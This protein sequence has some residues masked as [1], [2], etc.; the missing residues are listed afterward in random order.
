MCAAIARSK[1]AQQRSKQF[2][3]RQTVIDAI[4]D[5][6]VSGVAS[7]EPGASP[8]LNCRSWRRKRRRVYGLP[9]RLEAQYGPKSC[10]SDGLAVGD[11]Q[12][13]LRRLFL[14]RT[15][16][17]RQP[18][19]REQQQESV[20]FALSSPSVGAT[21]TKA[22]TSPKRKRENRGISMI[23]IGPPPSGGILPHFGFSPLRVFA[24]NFFGLT[25]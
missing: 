20:S 2:C 16:R 17:T 13:P 8:S 3:P 7:G 1:R 18:G 9:P 22:A 6:W 10:C 14:R 21:S 24:V 11:R 4:A 23:R 19:E 12:D 5:R 25:H 15:K